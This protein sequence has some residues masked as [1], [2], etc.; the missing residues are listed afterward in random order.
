MSVPSNV[1]DQ[2]IGSAHF[3]Q[4]RT[5]NFNHQVPSIADNTPL[6]IPGNYIIPEQSNIGREQPDNVQCCRHTPH[7]L[8]PTSQSP[9][10]HH[11]LTNNHILNSP[12]T[13][14]TNLKHPRTP[15]CYTPDTS[16]PAHS[17]PLP[18]LLPTHKTRPPSGQ[19]RN[20]AQTS[21]HPPLRHRRSNWLLPVSR[22]RRLY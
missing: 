9:N 17:N 15:T 5:A 7:K 12:T 19:K 10:T 16:S 21:H 4:V 11:P 8:R 1:I 3:L 20:M 18:N 2:R 6:V 22:L 14:T 13:S